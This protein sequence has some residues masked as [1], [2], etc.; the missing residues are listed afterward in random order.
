MLAEIRDKTGRGALGVKIVPFDME[1]RGDDRRL[2]PAYE[3]CQANN[4]P[5]LSESAGRAGVTSRPGYFADALRQ[6]PR[7]KLIFAHFGHSPEFGQGSDAEVVELAGRYENVCAD[8][9]LRLPEVASGHVTPEAMVAH[10]RKIGMDRVMYGSNF[11]FVEMIDQMRNP[12][13]QRP[14]AGPAMAQ[15]QASLQVL[16]TLP[17][18]DGEREQLASKNF[19]RVTGLKTA[20]A[21]G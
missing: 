1:I 2:F 21:A 12:A 8:V 11:V 5:I 10:L 19:K 20:V 6:F 13:W 9:S 3:Y 18:T 17:L 7:L 14:A 16:K 15:T 4:I